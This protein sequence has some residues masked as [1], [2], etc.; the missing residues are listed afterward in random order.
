MVM[1]AL[2]V[3]HAVR[4]IMVNNFIEPYFCTQ[5]H[6]QRNYLISAVIL[7]IDISLDIFH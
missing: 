3:D 1:S 5:I 6:K 7:V 4:V 2:E